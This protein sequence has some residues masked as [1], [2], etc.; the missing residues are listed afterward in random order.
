MKPG[1]TPEELAALNNGYLLIYVRAQVHPKIVSRDAV[2]ELNKFV[3][4]LK[5]ASQLQ[6]GDTFLLDGAW[7]DVEYIAY[8]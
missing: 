1:L 6:S 2:V 3:T 8:K 4:V 5:R 7:Y